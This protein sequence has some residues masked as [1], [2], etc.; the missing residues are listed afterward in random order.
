VRCPD[1]SKAVNLLGWRPTI[2]LEEG[3][4]RVWEYELNTESHSLTGLRSDRQRPAVA[5]DQPG[6][7][8]ATAS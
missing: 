4:R 1:I 5:A 3:L 6:E 8:A 2:R 7:P